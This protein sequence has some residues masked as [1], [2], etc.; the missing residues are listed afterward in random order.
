[1]TPGGPGRTGDIGGIGKAGDIGA[2][3]ATTGTRAIGRPRRGSCRPLALAATAAIAVTLA[4]CS[5]TPASTSISGAGST[6]GPDGTGSVQP[7]TTFGPPPS[8][9]PPDESTP[10]VLDPALL[11]IL[12]ESVAGI[13]V[14]E[15]V[16]EAARALGDPGLGRI[17]S[18]VHAAVAVDAGSG[19]LVLA[20]IVRLRPGMFGAEAYR[21][22]RDSYD[23]GACAG[24]GGVVGRAEAAI[25]GRNTFV[26]SCVAGLHTYHVWLEEENVMI[27]ASA[28]GDGQFGEKLIEGLRVPG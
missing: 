15:D 10:V 26:T 3:G 1:M 27:S 23:E 9:T 17:A 11:A 2:T 28:V 12:P 5:T 20:W 24:A 19:N 16:D 4:A 8:P 13:P 25:G 18:A 6:V 21:Q 14:K 7:P 22:W